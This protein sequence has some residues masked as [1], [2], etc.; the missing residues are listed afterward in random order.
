MFSTGTNSC[1]YYISPIELNFHNPVHPVIFIYLRI[2]AMDTSVPNL[3]QPN[4]VYLT[5]HRHMGLLSSGK[6]FWTNGVQVIEFKAIV[7][8]SMM[9]GTMCYERLYLVPYF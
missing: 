4:P 1:R 7:F 2:A 5:P 6:L 8:S 9:F 3:G